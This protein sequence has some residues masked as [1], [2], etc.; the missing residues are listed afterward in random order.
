MRSTPPLRTA[1]GGTRHWESACRGILWT[2]L[3]FSGTEPQQYCALPTSLHCF[4]KKAYFS[5]RACS[6]LGGPSA[7]ASRSATRSSATGPEEVS[8]MNPHLHM[9]AA[10]LQVLGCTTSAGMPGQGQWSITGSVLCT[11]G[12]PLT[13]HS[14]C[15]SMHTVR[16]PCLCSLALPLQRRQ[17]PVMCWTMAR[18]LRGRLHAAGMRL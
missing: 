5:R 9:S 14:V 2:A 10:A 15:G 16:K 12:L 4:S 17:G 6:S 11:D 7:R 18:R 13:S 3:L 8:H 1:P